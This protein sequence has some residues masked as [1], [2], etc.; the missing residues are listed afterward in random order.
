VSIE[1]ISLLLSCYIIQDIEVNMKWNQWWRTARLQVF[2]N[3]VLQAICRVWIQRGSSNSAGIMEDERN[4]LQIYSKTK[5]GTSFG[6]QTSD[7]S[8]VLV[9]IDMFR[10]KIPIIPF[11]IWRIYLLGGIY[12]SRSPALV[13]QSTHFSSY[14][15]CI[16]IAGCFSFIVCLCLLLFVLSDKFDLFDLILLAR[17]ETK[18]DK[19]VI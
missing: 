2:K 19:D 7:I 6:Y 1:Y 18:S 9:I 10:L 11:R 14:C 3:A 5:K 13:S 17:N 4:G 16:H 12:Q 8:N 15:V